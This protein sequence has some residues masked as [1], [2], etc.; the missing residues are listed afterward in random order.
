MWCLDVYIKVYTAHAFYVASED[1]ITVQVSVLDIFYIA[2]C[3]LTGCFCSMCKK[4][5][6]NFHFSQ[7]GYSQKEK[8][9]CF[10]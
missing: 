2:R 5:K 10:S 9:S 4:T 8:K 6:L 1:Q 3:C 7:N